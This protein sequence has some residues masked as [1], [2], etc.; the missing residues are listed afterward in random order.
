MKRVLALLFL[1][2]LVSGFVLAAAF[3]LGPSWVLAGGFL[4][5]IAG[6]MIGYAVMFLVSSQIGG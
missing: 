2:L 1:L 4:V 3:A 5:G 6:G